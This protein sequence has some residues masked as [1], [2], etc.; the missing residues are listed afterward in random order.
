MLF[1]LSEEEK[2]WMYLYLQIYKQKKSKDFLQFHLDGFFSAY[3]S[4]VKI[5]SLFLHV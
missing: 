2:E 4:E 5:E 1:A 3:I